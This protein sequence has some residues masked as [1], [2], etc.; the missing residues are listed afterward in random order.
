MILHFIWTPIQTS[1]KIDHRKI[2]VIGTLTGYLMMILLF[3][4]VKAIGL[5][6]S[7]DSLFVREIF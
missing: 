1:Y 7:N 3:R 2:R 4:H 5:H 6:I